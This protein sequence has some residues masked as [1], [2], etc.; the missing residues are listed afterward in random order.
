M[1]RRKLEP[2]GALLE[3]RETETSGEENLSSLWS[4]STMTMKKIGEE[5]IREAIRARKHFPSFNS[6]HEGYAV[7]LEELDEVWDEIKKKSEIRDLEHMR[8]EMIQ[9]GAMVLR[10]LYD[11]C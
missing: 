11:L 10:F 8:R 9:V 1:E 5:I 2:M 3:M 7:I 6:H 4:G